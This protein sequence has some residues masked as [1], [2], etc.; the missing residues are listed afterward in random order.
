MNPAACSGNVKPPCASLRANIDVKSLSLDESWNNV[1]VEPHALIEMRRSFSNGVA[2]ASM[3]SIKLIRGVRKQ[4]AVD[5][6]DTRI[7]TGAEDN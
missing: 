2:A 4:T 1:E 3:E 5:S 6:V 7:S